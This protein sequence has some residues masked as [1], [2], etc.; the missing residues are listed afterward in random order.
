MIMSSLDKICWFCKKNRHGDCMKKIPINSRS[1]GPH[2]CTF[3]MT[4]VMCNC[5][6]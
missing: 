1:I 3:D 4:L 2:D 5:K 6:H